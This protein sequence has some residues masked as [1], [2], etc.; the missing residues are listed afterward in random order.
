[1]VSA[2]GEIMKKNNKANQIF[3]TAG[4]FILGAYL[5]VRFRMEANYNE[6]KYLKGPYV[7]LGNHTNNW[8]PFMVS[9][10]IKEP[11]HFVTGEGNFKNPFLRWALLNL[12]GAI[13]KTKFMPDSTTIRQIIKV[14]NSNGIIGIFPEG[15]RNW[16]GVTGEILYSTSKLIKSLKLPVVTVV[17]KGAYMT[18]PRWSE[19]SRRGK[20]ELYYHLALTTDNIQQM[21]QEE[22]FNIISEN[23][24]HDDMQWQK[25]N[26]IAYKGANAERLEL[27]LFA[28]PHCSSLETLVSKGTEYKCTSC[29]YSVDYNEYGT[30]ISKSDILHFDSLY[31]WDKWQLG[32]LHK[33]LDSMSEDEL[34][35]QCNSVTIY[36]GRK[37]KNFSGK[38]SGNLILYKD[39]LVIKYNAGQEKE[40]YIRDMDGIN[41]NLSKNLEFFY[42]K[43]MYRIIFNIKYVSAYMWVSAIN[44]LKK[45]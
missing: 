21:S 5:K 2:M 30:I 11:I 13:P 41:V 14:K 27:F 7:I 26:N 8:D 32:L 35:F 40:F 31:E 19:K 34:A 3:N 24:Y 18:H 9:I 6:I 39:K 29:G 4:R 15:Q 36:E 38:L 45:K 33:K 42:N 10:Y 43:I 17:L 28:C 37:M 20:I 23:L 25:F 16:H 12:V 22:I 44:Y 1:M